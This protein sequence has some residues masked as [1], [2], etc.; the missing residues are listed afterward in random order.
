MKK[1]KYKCTSCGHEFE[2]KF[3]HTESKT[4]TCPSCC[5]GAEMVADLKV[6]I[7]ERNKKG[8]ADFGRDKRQNSA[9]N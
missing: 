3:V 2:A 1:Y 5:A 9:D 8:Y 4:A 7:D 6:R